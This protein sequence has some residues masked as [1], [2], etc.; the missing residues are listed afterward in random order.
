MAVA[1]RLATFA[2]VPQPAGRRQTV[3]SLPRSR[4]AEPRRAVRPLPLRRT[5][6]WLALGLLACWLG[7]VGTG[8]LLVHQYAQLVAV[9]NQITDLERSL[10]EAEG[11]KRLLTARVAAE[12]SLDRIRQVA[13]SRLGMIKPQNPQVTLVVPLADPVLAGPSITQEATGGQ[14]QALLGGFYELL[15]RARQAV[16]QLQV[17]PLRA[18]AGGR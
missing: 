12:G 18:E 8:L 3:P 1:E 9:Q 14:E 16:V 7:A 10:A 11:Q 5:R 4:T 17:T 15:G 6:R 2:A 13:E